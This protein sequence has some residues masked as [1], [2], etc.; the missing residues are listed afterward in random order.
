MGTEKQKAAAKTVG[1]VVELV[2]GMNGNMQC[3]CTDPKY[4]CNMCSPERLAK[5]KFIADLAQFTGTENYYKH[6]LGG[7][8]Y[9]DGVKFL[10]DEAEAYWLLD[11]I[12]SHQL[13]KVRTMPF[14]LWTL[15]VTNSNAVLSMK[16]DT[17]SAEVVHQDIPYTTFPL[18][19]IKLYLIDGVLLLPSEY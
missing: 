3:S 12:F 11:A 8:R 14:Q 18:D 7:F 16:E 2:S 5:L 13:R 1:E 4:V 19:E 15:T 10:A 6:W 9:T 17:G